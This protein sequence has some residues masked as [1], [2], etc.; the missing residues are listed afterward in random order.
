MPSRIAAAREFAV[1]SRRV[2]TPDGERPAALVVRAGRVQEILPPEAVPAGLPVED[3]GEAAVLPGLVD[4]HVHVNEPGRAEWEGFGPATRAAAAGG[5]TTLV[6]MPLNSL[7]V[8]TSVRALERKREAARGQVFVDCA[9]WGGLVPGGVGELGPLI[10]AGACG[11]KAFLVPS[12]I[13]E[14]PAAGEAELRAALPVLA[15]RGAPL[16][17][18]AEL[19]S[20]GPTPSGD[21]R[22]YA[23]WLASRPP[24]W[25]AAA[26]SLLVRLC[27]DTRSRVHVVHLSA[28][29]AAALVE[30]AAGDGLPLTAETC[31]HYLALEAEQVPDGATEW[32]CAPPVRDARNREALWRALGAGTLGLVVSDHSPCP[33]SLKAPATGDFLEAWGGIA[34]L[35]LALSVTWTEALAR[36]FGLADV[37][38]WMAREPARLCGL[39]ARKGQ[40]APGFDAD[41]VVFDPEATFVVDASALHHRHKLTPYA[42]RRLRGVVEATYLRGV[43][44]FDHGR[45]PG[46]P[47]GLLLSSA[48]G[49][50]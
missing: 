32:K 6:D 15:D 1:R 40:L 50:H 30:G 9:F 39:G 26:V 35:Q 12:G 4:S 34:S 43:R 29:E 7:P 10:D 28:A 21:P 2:V 45:L 38:R 27:R 31:P 46:P 16:L 25:E 14:F 8:T 5:V 13:D 17:V 20:G 11:V 24:S 3:V 48:H 22:R 19:A 49:L 37:A 23:T 44:V 47:T 33:A 36:G 41:L 18:H 42:G